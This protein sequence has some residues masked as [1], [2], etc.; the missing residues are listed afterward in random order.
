VEVTPQ[1]IRMRKIFLKEHERET[2]CKQNN[3]LTYRYKA[4]RIYPDS[5][6]YL[7]KNIKPL[8]F[9][10]HIPILKGYNILF[11]FKLL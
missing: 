5:F 4:V 11:P 2:R 10:Q 8:Y 3:H 7:L 6:F 1:S 9:L